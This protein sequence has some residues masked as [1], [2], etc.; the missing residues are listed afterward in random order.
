MGTLELYGYAAAAVLDTVTLLWI[1]S[2]AI[3]DASIIDVFWG[4]LFVAI[5]WVLF[6]ANLRRGAAQTSLVVVPR[7]RVGSAARF[8]PGSAQL[9]RPVKTS[10]IACGD[11]T[12]ANWWLKTYYRVYLL[13]GTIAL[14]VATPVV[15]AFRVDRRTLSDQLDRSTDLGSRDSCSKPTPTSS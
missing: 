12:A 15:A 2:V 5:A 1:V 7:H 8:P 4:P 14:V 6:A 9:R 3:R 10:A 11:R 13:Q